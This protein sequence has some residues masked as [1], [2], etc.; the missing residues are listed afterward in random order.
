M[1]DRYDLNTCDCNLGLHIEETKS[2]S[3]DW[4]KYENFKTFLIT[5]TCLDYFRTP[6]NSEKW[7]D[8]NGT[9][10]MKMENLNSIKEIK[11]AIVNIN[12]R[13]NKNE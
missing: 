7:L 5:Q 4:V 8:E 12:Q 6:E 3:G 10:L 9:G 1:I 2:D 13:K 11:D